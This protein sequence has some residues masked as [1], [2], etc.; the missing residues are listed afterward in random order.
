MYSPSLAVSWYLHLEVP[1]EAVVAGPRPPAEGEA[2]PRPG[3]EAD[4][5][6]AVTR[7]HAAARPRP[8]PRPVA[9]RHLDTQW[10]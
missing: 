1:A 2:V 9:L 10:W 7:G 5:A 4:A 3:L 6:E 8:R